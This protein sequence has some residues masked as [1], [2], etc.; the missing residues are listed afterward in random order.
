MMVE[1]YQKYKSSYFKISTLQNEYIVVSSP[2]KIQEFLAAKDD[3]LSFQESA[4]DAS[5]LRGPIPTSR[6]TREYTDPSDTLYPRL[7]RWP[8]PLS[9]SCNK[10]HFNAE[11]S[12][13]CSH[14]VQADRRHVLY[15]TARF[16]RYVA[17]PNYMHYCL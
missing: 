4:N 3:V 13:L 16:Y 9:S 6:L 12:W 15:N 2:D 10:E 17:S 7:E 8:Q 5:L 1:G 14:N 11:N